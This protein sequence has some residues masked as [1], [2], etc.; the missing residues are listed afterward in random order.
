MAKQHF[1]LEFGPIRED[2]LIPYA[3]LLDHAFGDNPSP[4]QETTW[5]R[6]AGLDSFRVVR[7]SGQLASGMGMLRMGQWFGGR[8]VPTSGIVAVVVAPEHRGGGVGS[9]MMRTA[10]EEMR[11]DGLALSAL[12]ASTQ[13]VYRRLGYEQAGVSVGYRVPLATLPTRDKS[14]DLRAATAADE[15]AMHQLYTEQARRTNGNLDRHAVMWEWILRERP[16]VNAYIVERD[17]T[18]EG[19]VVYA[20]R[21]APRDSGK[22]IRVR[23]LVA[24]TPDAARR[25]L[26]FLA[27]HRRVAEHLAWNGPAADP[28]VLH[29]AEQDYAV[30]DF[31]QWLIRVLNVSQAL[32]ARGYPMGATAE[33]HLAVRDDV[34]PANDGPLVLSIANGRAKVR[35]GGEGRVVID[36]RGLAPLYSGYLPPAALRGV[37]YLDGP[38]E[39]LA[40]LQTI[41]AG[42]GPWM[43]DHF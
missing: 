9:F 42:P 6:Q 30:P 5:Q 17:G 22:A 11:A 8:S 3:T 26:S 20:Q 34:L 31:Q 13:G 28:L 41:F 2:E 14:L 27:D 36:V 33:V 19:Y 15:P 40:L 32:A 23:D 16:P 7:A 39:D 10:L 29:L 35:P 21:T 25:L 1:D 12:Y 43:S 4:T 38:D 18:P 37:G 24:G